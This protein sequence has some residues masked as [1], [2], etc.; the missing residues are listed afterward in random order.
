MPHGTPGHDV[1]RSGDG[2]FGSLTAEDLEALT[3]RAGLTPGQR[4]TTRAA[5][6]VLGFRT[7]SYVTEELIDWSAAPEDPVYR[8]VV[9]D[10]DML[11]A[12]DVN[13][14]ADMLRRHVPRARIAAAARQARSRLAGDHVPPSARN[15][16]PGAYRTYRDT[17]ASDQDLIGRPF[18]AAFDPA[19]TWFTDLKPVP[20]GASPRQPRNSPV[21][22][23]PA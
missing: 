18:L 3:A 5:A 10:G 4:L 15:V 8:L 16:L 9:P 7:T 21:P 6:A 1:P 12:D 17:Q 22:Q 14:I 23:A 19:A 2:R 11:P 20:G 13:R